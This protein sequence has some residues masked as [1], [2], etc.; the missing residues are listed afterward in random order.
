MS[1]VTAI[2]GL[3]LAIAA[4]PAAPAASGGPRTGQIAGGAGARVAIRGEPT[5]RIAYTVSIDPR[6]ARHFAIHVEM[7]RPA[8]SLVFAIPAW[9]PGY[10][11]ILHYEAGID[12][13]RARDETGRPLAVTH[14]SPRTWAIDTSQASGGK[15]LL[16]YDVAAADKGLGFFGSMVDF[17]RRTG[18]INGASA[19]LYA[20]GETAAPVSLTVTLP[21]DWQCAVPLDREPTGIYR[22]DSYDE[23][24]DSPVQLGAFDTVA[25]QASGVPFR[26]IIAGDRRAEPARLRRVLA[27]IA[28]E[29]IGLFGGAP[30]R[31]YLFIYHVGEAGFIGGLEHRAST[32][33]HLDDPIGDANDDE[34]IT[35]SAHELF[36][37]WNVKRIRPEGLGPFDY[38]AAVRTP[39]LW[40]AEGVTDYYA[41]LTTVRAGIRT[42][43]W[44]AEQMAQRIRL[45]DGTPARS[46]VTLEE[47]SR[48]AWEGRSEGYDGL[49]YY[50]KGCLV[51]WLL[52]L[53]LRE[54]T[55]DAHSLD[56]V[57]RDLDRRF[58]AADTAYPPGALAEA[59]ERAAG[60]DQAP[61]L[62]RYAAATDE[63]AWGQA[64]NAA[65][66]Q[67]SRQEDGTIGMSVQP[68]PPVDET[69]DR[70]EADRAAIVQRVDP[71]LPAAAM[72]LRPGDRI[73]TIDGNEVTCGLAGAI[74]RSLPARV[75]IQ[76]VVERHGRTLTLRGIT[77]PQYSHHALVILPEAARPAAAS[78]ILKELF[79]SRAPRE[80]AAIPGR[81]GQ[82]L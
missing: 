56:D 25:F 75:P 51:G 53:Q 34:L 28:S 79:A 48:H 44:F 15:I 49:S 32:V 11:Q 57:I 70:E 50:V 29:E 30:F 20:V 65:G 39:S 13:V 6:R 66:F 45:L 74:L 58:G 1:P 76:V 69:D 60:R 36:H 17:N 68:E 82:P 10:Y 23:L 33:I 16:D 77:A 47:A 12:R 9:T 72:D 2:A 63:I 22:A 52:D 3:L 21:Q 37:A 5:Q 78:R 19:F 43:Q 38:S 7:P 67:L 41:D 8:G 4:T 35:T 80:D 26:C 14:D 46:K 73:L 40:F 81:N 54:M 71:D 31:K 27:A 59:I 24:I 61:L 64:L 62:E 42:P 18:Y 55:G